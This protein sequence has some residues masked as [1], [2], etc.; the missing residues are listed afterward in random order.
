M[1]HSDVTTAVAE[2]SHFRGLFGV[3]GGCLLILSALG[4]SAWGPF[5]HPAAFVAGVVVLGLAAWGLNSHYN[6]RYG[7][8]R[9]TGRHHRRMAV[10][11]FVGAPAIFFGSLLLS[12]RASWSLDLP[13][14]TIA[15]SMALIM[16]MVGAATVGVRTHHV[17]VYGTL[18]VAGLL[19]VWE[20]EGMS[21]NT[22][23]WMAGIAL[24]ISGLLDHR[25]LVRR[26]G[27]GGDA[28]A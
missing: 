23:L 24:I 10:A 3:V 12:S 20:R 16:L 27:S 17:V 6:S 19:P 8:S 5:E 1:Q 21:G 4:N 25:L 7:W 26:F 2:N 28:H 9:P 15:I 11:M 13:L 22:G 18:L 14:N